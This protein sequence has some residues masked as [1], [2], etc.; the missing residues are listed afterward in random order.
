MRLS[1]SAAN[2]VADQR[3]LVEGPLGHGRAAQALQHRWCTRAAA[4]HRTRSTMQLLQVPWEQ[5]RRRQLSGLT[6]IGSRQIG[7]SDVVPYTASPSAAGRTAG[8]TPEQSQRQAS[9]AAI[10]WRAGQGGH[11]GR[12]Q[13]VAAVGWV[14]HS[15]GIAL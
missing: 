5:G 14:A 6:W 3:A 12:S 11:P 7:Q 2:G 9:E 10:G 1:V 4:P 13:Q 8:G 15:T